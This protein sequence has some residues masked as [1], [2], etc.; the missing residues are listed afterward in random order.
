MASKKYKYSR[1]GMYYKINEFLK[2]IKLL[3]SGVCLIIGDSL[4]NKDGK[5]K[6]TA[7]I[8][9]LPKQGGI[10]SPSYPEVD[11][12]NMPYSDNM[13]D[14]VLSDQVL[15]HVEKPWIAIDEVHR[16]LKVGGLAIFTTCLIHGIHGV[17]NDYWRFTPN[18]LRVL[19]EKF[20]HIHQADG[21]GN[22][23]FVIKCLSGQRGIRVL[24]GTDIEKE[25]LS[26]DNINFL[27][28]W[29][30]AEK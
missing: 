28:I 3:K 22:L 17:P 18:G 24:P 14:Y 26:N 20:T 13:F 6:N 19:F 1:Y 4:N 8:D 15:E 2:T 30:I 16:V 7:L 12:Q 5:I 11:I 29:I 25:T 9:M 23:R 21:I 10:F 27:N